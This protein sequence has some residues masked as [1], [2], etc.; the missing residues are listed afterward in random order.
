MRLIV[1]F[2][3]SIKR[4]T[5]KISNVIRAVTNVGAN[6]IGLRYIERRWDYSQLAITG[7]IFLIGLP[8][9]F[10]FLGPAFSFLVWT[11]TVIFTLIASNLDYTL[12]SISN[13]RRR[14]KTVEEVQC[15]YTCA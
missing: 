2:K 4:I 13:V 7:W 15:L 8:V 14:R 12:E 10:I 3:T 11:A 1:I 6:L 9:G 5:N